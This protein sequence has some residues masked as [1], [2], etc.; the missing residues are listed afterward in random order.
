MTEGIQPEFGLE[1]IDDEVLAAALS[2]AECFDGEIIDL[3]ADWYEAST[4]SNVEDW[5]QQEVDELIQQDEAALDEKEKKLL[6]VERAPF[7][8]LLSEG[9]CLPTSQGAH[10]SLSQLRHWYW[11]V[12]QDS[13][14]QDADLMTQIAQVG[15]RFKQLHGDQQPNLEVW[16]EIEPADLFRCWKTYIE[17]QT[18]S[19]S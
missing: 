7:Q 1:E 12:R 2:L 15:A 17:A 6:E 5:A 16:F 13:E 3:S 8:L 18:G 19:D 4:D 9:S 10:V 14:G 11:Q